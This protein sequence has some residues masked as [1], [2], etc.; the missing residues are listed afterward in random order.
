MLS[1]ECQPLRLHPM[2]FPHWLTVL[3]V[4]PPALG[5]LR[6]LGL[7][8]TQPLLPE[9]LLAQPSLDLSRSVASSTSAWA[10]AHRFV[11]T[12]ALRPADSDSRNKHGWVSPGTRS[13]PSPTSH[14]CVSS[15]L[16]FLL[17]QKVSR[18]TFLG[19]LGMLLQLQTAETPTKSCLNMISQARSLKGGMPGLVYRHGHVTKDPRAPAF[20]LSP[21]LSFLL[22]PHLPLPTASTPPLINHLPFVQKPAAS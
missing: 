4:N 1:R 7:W 18:N 17:C 14:C 15:L 9:L 6:P 21:R 22:P 3:K 8:N 20:S 5:P 12:R 13:N 2:T 11:W 10:Y 19:Q 16:H